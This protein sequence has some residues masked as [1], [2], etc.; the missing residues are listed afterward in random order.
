MWRLSIKKWNATFILAALT[1]NWISINRKKKLLSRIFI[2]TSKGVLK[3]WRM[4]QQCVDFK[5]QSEWEKLQ[6]FAELFAGFCVEFK[7]LFW[8]CINFRKDLNSTPVFSIIKFYV[9]LGAIEER[10]FM[11]SCGAMATSIL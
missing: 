3:T 7:S 4:S 5:T 9:F 1:I 2:N 10:R 8:L 11:W 6:V